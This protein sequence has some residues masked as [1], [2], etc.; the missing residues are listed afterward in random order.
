MVTVPR[1]QLSQPRSHKEG[2]HIEEEKQLTEHWR[3]VNLARTWCALS[4]Q[5]ASPLSTRTCQKPPAQCILHINR[6]LPKT[7]SSPEPTSWPQVTWTTPLSW[8]HYETHRWPKPTS[9]NRRQT[10]CWISITSISVSRRKWLSVPVRRGHR[11]LVRMDR[12][13]GLEL[14]R[15]VVGCSWEP[16]LL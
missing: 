4:T 16:Q 6:Q 11:G 7:T 14:H 9:T 13:W 10:C 8:K 2:L 15:R 5:V 12:R 3:P 1:C